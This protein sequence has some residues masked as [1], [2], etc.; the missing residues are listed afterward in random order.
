MRGLEIIATGHFVPS[1]KVSNLD[2][3]KL[4]DTSDEWIVARTGISNRHFV[5]EENTS[6]LAV[7]AAKAA[8][9]KSGIE[10]SEI[11]YLIVAT[12]TPDHMCPSV[13]C[14]VQR[15]LG[16][17]ES[18]LAFDLNA[19][20][21]GFIYGLI[22]M[23]KLLHDNE[24][25]GLVI[26]CEVISKV[27]DFTDRGTCILFGDGAGAALVKGKENSIFY[28]TYGVRGND[29]E[30]ICEGVALPNQISDINVR[31]DGT[32]VFR[33]AVDAVA[34][35]I[36]NLF[37]DSKLTME[38][39]DYVVCHQANARIISNVQR[40]L[41]AP[42]E[43]FFMNVSDYANTSAASV[44]IALSEMDQQGLLRRGMKILCV[45]FGAGFTWG[46]ILLEW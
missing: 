18:I 41:K 32:A 44:P 17:D 23:E 40:G 14:L 33:F 3:S 29:T 11:G 39:I 35:V 43:K 30:L 46:G 8:I 21:S 12:F 37:E 4:V 26:G 2:M 36:K 9:E 15:E 13:S 25:Y 16:L 22:T 6:T 20:C 45:G 1:N 5:E 7:K 34:K 27:L 42:K 24:K 28:E 10:L 19:A 31:M 38:D